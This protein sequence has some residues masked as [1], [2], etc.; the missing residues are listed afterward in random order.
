MY[1]ESKKTGWL[2]FLIKAIIAVIFVLFVVWLFSLTT[3]GLSNNIS[4]YGKKL[5]V[6]TETITTDNFSRLEQVGKDYF[7]TARLPQNVGDVEKI[8]LKELYEKNLILEV[9][10]KNGNA[11]SADNSYISVTKLEKEYQMKIYLECGKSKDFVLVNMGCYDTCIDCNYRETKTEVEKVTQYQYKKT[12]DGKWSDYGAWSEWSLNKA[13]ASSTVQVESKNVTETYTEPAISTSTPVCEERAGYDVTRTGGTCKYTKSTDLT[14]PAKNGYSVSQ[15]GS[16]CTY[17]RTTGFDYVCPAKNGY[18]V[19]R[20]GSTCTY[21]RNVNPV[22]AERDGFNVTRS[23]FTCKYTKTVEQAEQFIEQRTGRY[24]PADTETYRYEY[25]TSRDHFDGCETTCAI[26]TEIIYNVYRKATTTTVT[27]TGTA[28][29]PS[30]TSN[31]STCVVTTTGTANSQ[32]PSGYTNVNGTCKDT[33]TE[34]LTCSSGTQSGATCTVTA[35]AAAT[36]SD[37]TY[38]LNGS[39]CQ[40]TVNVTKTRTVTYYRERSKTYISGNVTYKWSNSKTD[41]TLL[42]A[43]YKLTGKTRKVNK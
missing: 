31:G 10:D 15:N 18:N 9:K 30:G 3:K 4:E 19:T 39:V 8:T 35:T 28:T 7:T 32:C 27:E 22:C 23:G 40:K 26:Y 12:T 14:C 38:T 17:T 6:L 43:G 41:K 13:T 5:D 36:C 11:C 16:T 1:E 42:D 34:T 21:T 33:K 37:K 25:V 2:N 29:C 20:S 24:L